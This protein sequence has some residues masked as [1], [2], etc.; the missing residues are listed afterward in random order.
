MY[1]ARCGALNRGPEEVL[2]IPPAAPP[3]RQ[4]GSIFLDFLSIAI[5]VIVLIGEWSPV[6]C[7]LLFPLFF[8][9]YR[10]L[11][12]S[13]GRQ[14]F[15]Q[16][17]FG[18]ATISPQAGPVTFFE[19]LRRSLWEVAKAPLLMRARTEAELELRTG[20]LEVTLV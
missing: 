8:V 4:L 5:L 2:L 11:G 12:R 15:G 3:A 19:G 14:S 20:T 10:T 13:G 18:I 7:V 9:F 1:C 17:V 6:L 16:S